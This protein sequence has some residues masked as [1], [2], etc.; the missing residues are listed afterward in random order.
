MSVWPGFWLFTPKAVQ[1]SCVDMLWG[2]IT[3]TSVC[4][5]LYY[6]YFPEGRGAPAPLRE[7]QVACG[8]NSSLCLGYV[9]S[10]SLLV[11]LGW[12][13]ADCLRYLRI[14]L[15]CLD[16][17]NHHILCSIFLAWKP[18]LSD[19]K[20]I[21]N[22]A[23]RNEDPSLPQKNRPCSGCHSP[24]AGGRSAGWRVQSILSKHLFKLSLK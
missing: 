5:L 1:N 19:R 9:S 13:F 20:Q 4:L 2:P 16:G 12:S 15:V 21:L 7:R 23:P 22:T 8:I 18:S 6:Q 24:A 3:G 14:A 11:V 17:G 10:G